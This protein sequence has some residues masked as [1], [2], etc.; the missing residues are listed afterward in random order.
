MLLYGIP[1][2][3]LFWSTDPR[4]LS[5]FAE[6]EKMRRFVPFSK[7]PAAIKD[8]SFW[9][10]LPI[11]SSTAPSAA[12]G[13]GAATPSSQGNSTPDHAFHENDVME[14]AREVCGDVVEDVALVDAFTHPKT[15]RRSMCYR[16]HYRS[17]ERTLTS[18][19]A[20]ELHERLRGRLVERLGVELR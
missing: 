3:R 16:C 19:E 1:D 12:G 8:V 15:G 10:P 13:L 5:Q 17:L 7:Y 11:S 14:I 9:L 4:F 18:E 2:I 6:G 20:N